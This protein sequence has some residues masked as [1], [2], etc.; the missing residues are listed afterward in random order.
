[1][2]DVPAHVEM[3][4]GLPVIVPEVPML[5]M[6]AEDVRDAIDRVRHRHLLESEDQEEIEIEIDPISENR[7]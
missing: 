4:D 6:T 2:S 7:I 5:P 3:R 1:M